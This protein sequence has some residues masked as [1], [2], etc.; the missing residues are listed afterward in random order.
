MTS[1]FF[2]FRHIEKLGKPLILSSECEIKGD[3]DKFALSYAEDAKANF[4]HN[5]R[6]MD[7]V[8]VE[9][10]PDG[11]K[12][13]LGDS[14][15]EHSESYAILVA[16]EENAVYLYASSHKGLIYAVSTLIQLTESGDLTDRLFLFDYPDMDVRGYRVYTPSARQFDTFKAMVDKLVYYK[17]NSIIIEVGGA[18]EYKRH[19]EINEK[20][21]EFCDE[22]GVSP[23][24]AE[25]IQRFTYPWRKDS[26]HYENGEGGFITQDEMR[27]IVEYC[28]ERG[29][30]VIPEVPTLSH[31]DYIVRA[32]PELNERAEDAYPDTYCPS[33]P[34]T[35]E[36]VFDII[37]EV[38][39][40]FKPEYINIGH[41]EYYT[42]AICPLCKGKSPVDIYV[43]DI[44]KINDYLKSKNIKAM[45]WADKFFGDPVTGNA[46]PQKFVPDLMGCRGK[47]PTDVILL[48]WAW[49]HNVQDQERLLHKLGYGLM[50]G[51][52]DAISRPDYR[53]NKEIHSGGFVSN[54]GSFDE[55]YMQRN[56]QNFWLAN[57]AYVFWSADYTNKDAPAL[58]EKV[59]RELYND[60]KRT[61]GD[62]VIEI[63]HTT[64]IER[65]YIW[66]WCGIFIVDSDWLI[67][68]HKVTYTDGTEAELPVIYG[69]NIRGCDAEIKENFRDIEEDFNTNTDSRHVEAIGAS[70][71][72]LSDGKIWYKTAYANP[73]PDKEIAYITPAK[74]ILIKEI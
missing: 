11:I 37:D 12:A 36:I 16:P 22:V 5:G 70:Y 17:Y 40:V 52:F 19:P 45:M 42:V 38:V 4:S 3:K 23:D 58:Y 20:W 2:S 48:N 10:I 61:L 65:K 30:D 67:G 8:L 34:K 1:T 62:S 73:Y 56:Q 72:F 15:K 44:T 29:L 39:D 74:D 54:W 55:K 7:I 59:R 31:S 43:A 60:Y 24:V 66:F 68:N 53:A 69:Y 64:S 35:Y 49:P 47:V 9:N 57:T 46:Y 14:Y 18:M 28:K 21:V 51:N 33:N 32:F 25:R 71:P 50:F 41:D 13:R 26:I 6:N 27:E 63:C